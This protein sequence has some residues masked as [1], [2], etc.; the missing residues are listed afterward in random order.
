M[1]SEVQEF[2]TVHRADAEPGQQRQFLDELNRMENNQGKMLN[3][4]KDS[5][6]F[7]TLLRRQGQ[8]V[9]RLNRIR[10]NFSKKRQ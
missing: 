1:Y 6:A 5:K 9:T 3:Q 4:Y 7:K 2:F 10:E 8:V